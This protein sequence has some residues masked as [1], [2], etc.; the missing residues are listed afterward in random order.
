MWGS[1]MAAELKIKIDKKGNVTF[2]VNGM[3]GTTC[4]QLTEALVR[5]MGGE[6]ETTHKEEYILHNPDLIFN[7]EE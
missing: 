5:S 3:E 2:D 6:A 1:N 4:E 7:H